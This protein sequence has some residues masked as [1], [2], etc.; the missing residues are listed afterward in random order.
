MGENMNERTSILRGFLLAV[1]SLL[2][3]SVCFAARVEIAKDLRALAEE[4]KARDL[5]ILLAVSQDHCGF[6]VRL[7][8]EILR[9]MEI[10]GDYV[11][12]VVIRE[13]LIDPWVSAID[14]DGRKK[15]GA[16]IADRYRVWVTPTL[17]YLGPDGKELTPRM[18][19]I[20]T[21]EMYGYYV[22]EA[23]EAALRR[24]RGPDS[25]PYVPTREDIGIEQRR[26]D[27]LPD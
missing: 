5:V 21:V 1:L 17:L 8:E 16:E 13:L 19:G 25:T 27:A 22:D 3:P 20:Q 7:K 6:C 9:P 26:W 14:F 10:S 18:L 15:P 12:K 11:D 4:A 23:I 24:L 2:L